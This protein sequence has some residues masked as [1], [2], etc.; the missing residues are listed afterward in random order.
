MVCLILSG[1]IYYLHSQNPLF[2]MV[3][4]LIGNFILAVVSLLSFYIITRGIRSNDAN[5][6]V[7]ASWRV[8][9]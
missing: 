3:S 5:A 4:L 6:F 7:R 8:P 1:L 2:D 9:C